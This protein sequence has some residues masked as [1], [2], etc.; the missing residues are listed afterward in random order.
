M[1]STKKLKKR[2]KKD[3]QRS[4]RETG[5][6]GWGDGREGGLG[7][8]KDEARIHKI[9]KKLLLSSNSISQGKQSIS[10]ISSGG[11]H[12]SF[13]LVEKESKTTS[14]F[15][16]GN[17]K[18]AQLGFSLD[19]NSSI[20]S[21]KLLSPFTT[22]LKYVSCGRKHTAA[23][24]GYL[25]FFSNALFSLN[26]AISEDGKLY[27]FGY[28]KQGQL[29]LGDALESRK[30]STP[31]LVRFKEK[32]GSGTGFVHVV[33]VSCGG[34]HT[35]VISDKGELWSFGSNVYGQLGLGCFDKGRFLPQLVSSEFK[36][37]SVSCGEEH[38]AVISEGDGGLCTFGN[39]G[40][41]RCGHSSED[42]LSVPTIVQYF[43]NNSIFIEQ[44]SCGGAHTI[45]LTDEGDVYTFG[46]G[47]H[48]ELGHR[49]YNSK[50]KPTLVSSI[51]EP[52]L[53]VVA[54]LN[55]SAVLTGLV[56]YFGVFDGLISVFLVSG[57]LYTFGSGENCKLGHGSEYNESVPRKVEALL[58]MVIR[59][60]ACG[61][62]HT[63]AFI[64]NRFFFFLLLKLI[65]SIDT[66]YNH[67]NAEL[68]EIISAEIRYLRNIGLIVKVRSVYFLPLCSQVDQFSVFKN[69]SL[70]NL[71]LK[72]GK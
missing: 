45:A 28:G 70:R 64:G 57:N 19:G 47:E 17:N 55:F 33:H 65:F 18:Y 36:F 60:I 54:S 63:L 61:I 26:F 10:L 59:Q 32:D 66:G 48:G 68:F 49:R 34:L 38:T 22:K 46:N 71:A 13:L 39:G 50:K 9:P 21:P 40:N 24:T 3:L 67:C 2:I 6:W 30:T 41:Y 42:S 1:S 62:H 56:F 31:A 8:G 29:G 53:Q 27:T 37:T 43:K 20:F 35:C 15:A 11:Y 69:S 7:F 5:I 12:S 51:V 14:L 72:I 25:Y 44:V 16:F 52:C 58:P 4:E 23:I